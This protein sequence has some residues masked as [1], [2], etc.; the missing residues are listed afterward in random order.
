MKQTI[1]ALALVLSTGLSAFADGGKNINSLTKQSF[2]QEFVQA[3]EVSWQTEKGLSVANFSLD[4]QFMHAYYNDQSELVAVVHNVLSDHLPIFLFTDLK[5]NYSS[6][7][8]SGLSE[9]A[10]EGESNFY[11]TLENADQIIILKSV[12]STDWVVKCRVKKDAL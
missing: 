6:Y 8:I 2:T 4:G 12:N 1:F 11:A 7:W 5:K 3:S 9:V 10:S